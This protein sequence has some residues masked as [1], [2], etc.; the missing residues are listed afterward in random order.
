MVLHVI[1]TKFAAKVGCAA[2]SL[3]ENL[4]F[5]PHQR[6][7]L[8]VSNP[9]SGG[10][11]YAQALSLVQDILLIPRRGC[12][13][14][15][16]PEQAGIGAALGKEKGLGAGF[17]LIPLFR[18]NRGKLLSKQHELSPDCRYGLLLPPSIGQTLKYRVQSPGAQ[19][20]A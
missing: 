2:A 7:G 14:Q 16:L 4:L 1:N 15:E 5:L 6:P 18:C 19:R 13:D 11:F 9:T 8:A 10:L 12:Q 17:P 3:V 20:I